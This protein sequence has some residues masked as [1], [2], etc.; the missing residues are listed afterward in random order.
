MRDLQNEYDTHSGQSG[1]AVVIGAGLGG[2]AAA[3]RLGAKGWNVT[4]LDRL[5]MPGGRAS[6]ITSRGHRFDLGPTIVTAP[7]VF[8][9]LWSDCGEDFDRDV[10][11]R[12]LD[13]FYRITWPDGSHFDAF[14]Q[15]DAAEAE[16]A[17]L[18]PDDVKGWH[19]FL[20][21]AHA[22]YVTG[23]EGMLIE[24]MHRAWSTIRVLPRFAMLRADRS[25]LS[26]ARAR[27][28]DERLRMAL[29]FHPLFIGGDPAR[30]TSMYA[31]VSHLEAKEGVHYAMGGV[32]A[33]AEEMARIVERQGGQIR[34]RTEVAE[35]LTR[36]K[37]AAGVRL[38]DG[39]KIPA[40]IVVSNADA[41]HTYSRLL[42]GRRRWT[43][44]KLSRT[45]LSMG[46]F[47]WYFGTEETRHIWP[48]VGHH[49]ILSG[50]R[51]EGLLADVFRKGHLAD[52][53]SLYVHRPS[54][55]DPS[56]APAGG[57]TFYALSPVP[58][59]GHRDPVRWSEI[60]ES[61]RARV[62]AVLE[63]RLLPGLGD[64]VTASMCFTPEDFRDRYLSPYGAGF[65]IEPRILQS[66]WFRPHN[67]S[68]EVP[69]LFLVGAGTHPG[70]GLPGVVA[71]A[72][73]LERVV[74]PL[75]VVTADPMQ[76][77]AE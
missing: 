27:V 10:D 70:A 53:M 20:R 46:L 41:G 44:R 7:S 68:E 64:H 8:R 57:D 21:D 26:L 13:P 73:V 15:H 12:P 25:I 4:V 35:V 42:P 5:D 58:H 1:R 47:V 18:A 48:E 9:R 14:A 38:S 62:Q 61:Y 72:E 3:M 55:T 77:A 19:R 66:A 2:L 16:I 52:D 43:K 31:L 36:G 40:D 37:R 69:G 49:T 60:A 74:P 30:V 75:P 11:L 54:V 65:S 32:G 33:M 17:R 56:C 59:L 24:P 50:P 51:Y 22:R 29:S 71:S 39:E 67:V 76:Q 45:R 63:E 28:K 23:Y 34:Q 6:S